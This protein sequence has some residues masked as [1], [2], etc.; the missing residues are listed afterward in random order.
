MILPDFIVFDDHSGEKCNRLLGVCRVS[1]E[2]NTSQIT[3]FRRFFAPQTPSNQ[4]FVA[5]R[6]IGIFTVPAAQNPQSRQAAGEQEEVLKSR[7]S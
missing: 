1:P 2:L 4:M 3:W 7:R 6:I 5:R